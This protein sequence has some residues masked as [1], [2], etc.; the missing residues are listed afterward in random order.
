[1]TELAVRFRR[2]QSHGDRFNESSKPRW[3]SKADVALTLYDAFS[4][5]TYVK[6]LS[7]TRRSK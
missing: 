3:P 4:E 2:Q 6:H 7:N 5:E 1:M